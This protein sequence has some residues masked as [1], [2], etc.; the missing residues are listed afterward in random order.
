MAAPKLVLHSTFG[1]RDST[2]KLKLRSI[3]NI[4]Y[5]LIAMKNEVPSPFESSHVAL[6]RTNFV[7]TKYEEALSIGCNDE[8][9]RCR[10]RQLEWL[11]TF[12]A[13]E[14]RRSLR[15]NGVFVLIYIFVLGLKASCLFFVK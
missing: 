7:S 12:Q 3:I 5:N 2:L 6:F 13:Q 8:F 1:I 14:E 4:C 9:K 10:E 11:R 15:K